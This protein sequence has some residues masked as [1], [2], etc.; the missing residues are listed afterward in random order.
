MLPPSCGTVQETAEIRGVMNRRTR[1]IAS[2]ENRKIALI[3]D[4]TI[5]NAHA[6]LTC[7]KYNLITTHKKLVTK[8]QRVKL[9]NKR[10]HEKN[11][12]QEGQKTTQLQEQQQ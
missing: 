3:K 8:Q 9:D 1:E 4:S 6:Q 2:K 10:Q 7:A 11:T 5:L 12:Q